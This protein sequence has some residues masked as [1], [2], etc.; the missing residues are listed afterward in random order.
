MTQKR[1]NNPNWRGGKTVSSHGYILIRVGT[2]HHL[3][4]VRGYAYEHRIVAEK[5]IGR[6]LK[7]GERIHHINK[8]KSDNRPKNIMVTGS[9]AEHFL[10]HRK[11][12][13]NRRLPN[14]SNPVIECKCGCGQTL[15]KYDITSRPRFYV[16][17]HNP[18]PA[19]TQQEIIQMLEL[20]SLHRNVLIR[21]C[22]RSPGSISSTLNRL[23]KKGLVHQISHGV[24]AL[25]SGDDNEKIPW[26]I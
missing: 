24:W 11:S 15:L 26:L 4:D 14:E 13:S 20:G 8:N 22:K 23:K 1:E 9:N 12:N 17:G 21:L 16:S 10:Q 6:K 18:Q 3:A 5:K 2:D 19:F 25:T 7:P